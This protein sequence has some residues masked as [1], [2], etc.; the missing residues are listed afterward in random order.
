MDLEI[1]ILLIN[2]V[3]ISHD[4]VSAC[5]QDYFPRQEIYVHKSIK[6]PV[7]EFQSSPFN[8]QNMSDKQTLNLRSNMLI[9]C[10]TICNYV[11][12]CYILTGTLPQLRCRMNLLVIYI[13]IIQQVSLLSVGLLF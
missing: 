13:M 4:G 12:E 1:L 7:I 8:S 11:F 10:D 2:P 5:K 6:M 9:Y 3:R